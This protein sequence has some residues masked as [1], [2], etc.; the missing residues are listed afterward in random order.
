MVNSTVKDLT[1]QLALLENYKHTVSSG[2]AS[3]KPLSY[4]AQ[5][6]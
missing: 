4:S 2:C 1:E 5:A 3:G 6:P